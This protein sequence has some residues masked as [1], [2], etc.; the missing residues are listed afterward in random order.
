[1]DGLR[2]SR[3]R[4]SGR[5]FGRRGRARA[6]P[7]T[8]CRL[9]PRTACPLRTAGSSR[10]SP[11]RSHSTT[12]ASAAAL[13]NVRLSE[14]TARS[15]VWPSLSGE[16]TRSWPR[17]TSRAGSPAVGAAG[18]GGVRPSRREAHDLDGRVVAA[19]EAPH[20]SPRAIEQTRHARS[21]AQRDHAPVGAGRAGDS[22]DRVAPRRARR[23]LEAIAY[24]ASSWAL[25]R[26]RAGDER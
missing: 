21:G 18:C 19:P 6:E 17:P 26:T 15:G 4:A 7:G 23:L 20:Q 16:S 5:A 11:A 1:M 24:V 10:R 22:A 12:R 25:S 13:Y 2:R 9:P 3:R 14:V 8:G